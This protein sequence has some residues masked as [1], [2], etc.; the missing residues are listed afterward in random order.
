ME[1]AA[2]RLPH[3][4]VLRYGLLYSP[5]TWYAPG[6]RIAQDVM[7]GKVPATPQVTSF[8]HIE[9][10]AAATVQALDCW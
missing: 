3:C 4:T 10:A 1:A 5:G 2:R 8:A 9:D 6:G 7:A